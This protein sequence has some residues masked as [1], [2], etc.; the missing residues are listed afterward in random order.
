MQ[1]FV[2]TLDDRTLTLNVQPEDTINEIKEIVEQ[3]EG[4]PSEEQRLTLGGISLDDELTLNECRVEEESTLYVLLDLEGGGKKRKKKSYNTPKKNKHKHK[5]VK[6]AVLKYYK[7]EDTG[8]IRRLRRECQSKQC[9]AGVFM[10]AH[11]DR[12]YCGKCAVTYMFTKR[13]EEE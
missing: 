1:I 9:G 2:R 11:H 5:K 12:N 10:A 3:R 4:I 6:L 13:E 7:V 8:K